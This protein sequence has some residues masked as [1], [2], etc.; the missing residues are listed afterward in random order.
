MEMRKRKHKAQLTFS[1]LGW[2]HSLTSARCRMPLATCRK[3]RVATKKIY[4][5]FMQRQA[6]ALGRSIVSFSEHSLELS[7]CKRMNLQLNLLRFWFY[8][9]FSRL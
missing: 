8:T 1:L 3:R 4:R 2:H 5:G 7:S 9:R 6:M